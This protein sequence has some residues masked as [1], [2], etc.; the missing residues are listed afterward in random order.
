MI[1]LGQS[2]N[3]PSDGGARMPF[4][5]NGVTA[6]RGNSEIA[7]ENTVIAFRKAI[8]IGVDWIELDIRRSRDGAIVVIHDADVSRTTNGNGLVSELTLPQLKQLD[9]GYNFAMG[10]GRIFPYRGM[11]V[12]IPTL[13]EVFDLIGMQSQTRIS[14]QPKVKGIVADAIKL[15]DEKNIRHLIGFNDGNLDILSEAIEIDPN[16]PIFWDTDA[17][18]EN[19]KIAVEY[20]IETIVMNRS[21]V[22]R[23]KIANIHNAGMEAGVW[24]VNALEEMLSFLQ[25]GIDRMYTDRPVVLIELLNR[26]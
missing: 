4:L 14:I 17:T 5:N 3:Y 20:G 26:S 21:Q 6:H 9:A 15:A 11:G 25:M 7:P 16:I 24:I 18:D 8:D 13:D 1:K 12:K 19:I 2:V 10:F 23:A 22:K